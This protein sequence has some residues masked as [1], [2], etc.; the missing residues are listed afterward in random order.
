[1]L[2]CIVGIGAAVRA[3]L[4][5]A[6]PVS[7]SVPP[8]IIRASCVDATRAKEAQQALGPFGG[9][10]AVFAW[11]AWTHNRP[12]WQQIV[13]SPRSICLLALARWSSC[14]CTAIWA[15]GSWVGPLHVRGG[16]GAPAVGG[17]PEVTQ[18]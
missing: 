18:R 15:R 6:R 3:G 1:M 12:C 16:L 13:V 5:P 17:G 7:P 9:W 8:A 14:T 11:P 10:S 4:A 2:I